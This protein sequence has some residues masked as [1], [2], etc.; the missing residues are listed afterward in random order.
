MPVPPAAFRKALLETTAADPQLDALA[1]GTPTVLVLGQYLSALGLVSA[2]EEIAM[3]CDMVDRAAEWDP[4]RIVFKPHPSAPPLVTDA[5]RRRAEAHGAEFVEYRGVESAEL[6]AE[7]LEAAGVIAGFSTALPTVQ[8]LF[9]RTIAS[10]G[11]QTVLRRL[12]PYENSN[13]IPATIVD[14]LTRPDD[15]HREPAQLQLLIDAVG[16]AMQPKIAAHLRPRAEELLDGLDPAERD[17]Y[18]DSARLVEL[19]LPGAPAEPIVRRALRSV[20]GV[21]RAEEIRLTIKGARRRA[22]RVWKVARGL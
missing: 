8:A 4:R 10:S 19:R 16:Y 5:V 22:A 12:T 18:F 11:T 21:G 7:R 2:A 1:D 3:Q 9:D 14:A 15:R 20:G 6:V 13:R 17:R